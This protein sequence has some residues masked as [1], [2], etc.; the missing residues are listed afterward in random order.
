MTMVP[1]AS[2]TLSANGAMF[3][4]DIPQT[5]KHLE[6]RI[7]GRSINNSLEASLYVGINGLLFSGTGYSWHR[8]RGDG[9]SA[10][11]FGTSGVGQVS[12]ESIL[13]A[14]QS[15]ASQFGVVVLNILDYTNTTKNKTFKALGGHDKNGSGN[16]GLHSAVLTGTAAVTSISFTPDAGMQAG[17][18][19]DLYGI[20]G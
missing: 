9:S 2:S 1:I 15:N 11:S 7:H 12:M 14:A 13:P 5:Y 20:V 8:L 3:F 16:V 10:T 6:L 17:S 18:R 4:N 19:A